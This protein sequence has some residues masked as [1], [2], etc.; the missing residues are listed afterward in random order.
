MASATLDEALGGGSLEIL[1]IPGVG[2]RSTKK[3]SKVSS[4]VESALAK[5]LKR[6]KISRFSVAP[7]ITVGDYHRYLKKSVAKGYRWRDRGGKRPDSKAK[8]MRWECKCCEDGPGRRLRDR[9]IA[10]TNGKD[11]VPAA[12]RRVIEREE[13]RVSDYMNRPGYRQAIREEVLAQT[14]PDTRIVIAHSLGSLV[15]VDLLTHSD[16]KPDLLITMG[17]PLSMKAIYEDL[18][19]AHWRWVVNRETDWVN[20]HNMSDY[21]TACS[22]LREDHFPAVRQI[23]VRHGG[24]AHDF[25]KH[26]AHPPVARLLDD[27]A[28]GHKLRIPSARKA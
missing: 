23:R 21:V 15:A 16:L 14:H 22:A 24:D 5:S 3:V 8:R 18:E 7:S 20:V 4:R 28:S 11:P 26:V 13:P 2:A 6:S 9:F 12:V 17:T 19:R 27:V 25:A 1:V 10:A